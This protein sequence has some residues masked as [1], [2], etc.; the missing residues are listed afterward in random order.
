MWLIYVSEKMYL[1]GW[2]EDSYTSIF[3]TAIII[4]IVIIINIIIIIIVF[5]YFTLFH[6]TFF[7]NFC[8]IISIFPLLVS[9]LRFCVKDL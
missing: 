3:F 9:I 8:N 4:I 1:P 6:N 5:F 7:L 2:G